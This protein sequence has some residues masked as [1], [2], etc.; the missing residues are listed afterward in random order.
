MNNSFKIIFIIISIIKVKI[1]EIYTKNTHLFITRKYGITRI[2]IRI[3]Y[4]LICIQS[5]KK[6]FNQSETNFNAGRKSSKTL[7]HISW[8][9]YL[10]SW[11]YFHWKESSK[12]IF[13]RIS[14]VLNWSGTY[15]VVEGWVPT[16][17]SNILWVLQH[18][19]TNLKAWGNCQQ[20]YH[21]FYWLF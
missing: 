7:L 19:G 13:S 12:T 4:I 20:L 2:F 8:V 6:F 18:S 15:S 11:E 9:L 14:W 5:R 3:E 16:A 10:S 17:F 1:I 21:T